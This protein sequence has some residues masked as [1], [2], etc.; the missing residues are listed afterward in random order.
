MIV[1]LVIKVIVDVIKVGKNFKI[2]GCVG[3]GVD[4]IDILVVFL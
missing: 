4:N 1:R 2:I 3:I